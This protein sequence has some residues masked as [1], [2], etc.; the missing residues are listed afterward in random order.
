MTA[1]ELGDVVLVRF[2]FT[3]LSAAKQ[4]PAVV[5][6]SPEYNRVR[7]DL[8]IA[9]ITSQPR[10]R[11]VFDFEIED[12]R[13]AGLLRP[14]I[15]KAVIATISVENVAKRLGRLVDADA[16]RLRHL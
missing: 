12:W 10:S 1:C 4:R 3:D 9:A 6:S 13:A 14:S 8:I 15:A 16:E 5:V 7:P 2:P 11:G